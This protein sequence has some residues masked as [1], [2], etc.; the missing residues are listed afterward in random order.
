[1]ELDEAKLSTA[2]QSFYSIVTRMKFIL[3]VIVGFFISVMLRYVTSEVILF[4]I[5]SYLYD[6]NRVKGYLEH[7]YETYVSDT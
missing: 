3:K 5:I 2:Y 1:M 4:K 6:Y 7:S